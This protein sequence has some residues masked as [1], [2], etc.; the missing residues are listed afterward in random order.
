MGITNLAKL[1]RFPTVL[2]FKEGS[3]VTIGN[4]DGL[5]LGHRFIINKVVEK[6]HQFSLVPLV[7]SFY[8]HP[9]KVLKHKELPRPLLS[10]FEQIKLLKEWRI[11]VLYLCRFSKKLYC[12]TAEQFLE[13]VL[14][15]K[16]NVKHLIMGEDSAFGKKR[17]GTPDVVRKLC[18]QKGIAFEEIK[19]IRKEGGSKYSSTRIRSLLLEG[20]VELVKEELGRL[21]TVRGRIVKGA[22]RGRN[23]GFPTANIYTNQLLPKTGI[24]ACWITFNGE[25]LKGA[26]S[27]GFRPTYQDT[28]EPILEVYIIDKVFQEE[29]YSAKVN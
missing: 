26:V 21:Y 19:L 2:R 8:P 6:A 15:Q 28:D 12:L 11:E 22:G 23:L 18:Q 4:F 5:H 27:L 29:L 16:L 24:Y 17:E 9:Q 7:V 14:I 3:C 20:K 25:K 13:E 1:F 10:R